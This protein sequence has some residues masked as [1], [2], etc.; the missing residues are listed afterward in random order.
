MTFT[1]K[2]GDT[3]PAIRSRLVPADKTQGNGIVGYQ[4]V[5]FFMRDP[6]D[7]EIVAEGLAEKSAND[8]IAVL[9]AANGD[10]SYQWQAGDTDE[11][12]MFEAEWEVTFGDGTIETFPND[13]YIDI[14]IMSDI[15]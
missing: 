1:I 4:K 13:G 12:G 7:Y 9:D 15:K 2:R 5:R 10:V 11:P 8:T 3:S 6:T 14:H